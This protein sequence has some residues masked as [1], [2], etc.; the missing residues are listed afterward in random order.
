MEFLMK[1]T[2]RAIRSGFTRSKW[3][4]QR[5]LMLPSAKPKVRYI[6]ALD[7][8]TVTRDGDFARIEYKE[9]DIAATLPNAINGFQ[10]A[11]CCVA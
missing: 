7:E 5:P 3:W 8:V 1:S 9:G 4:F 2:F 10:E 6:A 11:V